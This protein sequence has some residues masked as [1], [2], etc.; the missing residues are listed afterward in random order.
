MAVFQWPHVWGPR[1]WRQGRIPVTVTPSPD[2]L[3]GSVARRWL[4]KWLPSG[5]QPEPFGRSAT[6]TCR[7]PA[8]ATRGTMALGFG[9]ACRRH[10]HSGTKLDPA[11]AQSSYAALLLL[12]ALQRSYLIDS[13][14]AVRV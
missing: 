7:P 6:Q 8:M 2:G 3:W 1:R 12:H 5:G 11:H 13:E 4:P 14:S 9:L 10:S